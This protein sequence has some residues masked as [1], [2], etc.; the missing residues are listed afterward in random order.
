MAWR[1]VS[2]C[3]ER[4]EGSIASPHFGPHAF[5]HAQNVSRVID[6]AVNEEVYV[7]LSGT[8]PDFVVEKVWPRRARQPVGTANPIF[9][10]VNRLPDARIEEQTETSLRIWMG[11]CCE[12]C[13]PFAYV[14]FRETRAVLG[15]DDDIDLADPL[16]RMASRDEVS[17]LNVT[18]PEGH[19]VYCVVSCHGGGFDGPSIF[20]VA[21]DVEVTHHPSARAS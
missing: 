10:S 6:F 21:R 16:F 12:Q 7:A 17:A 3:A 8:E 9:A 4:G 19:H 13:S 15:L 11:D 1:I 14:T 20:V 18:V 2:F 5:G